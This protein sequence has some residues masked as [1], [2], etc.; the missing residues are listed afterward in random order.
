MNF[1]KLILIF[2]MHGFKTWSFGLLINKKI[3][4]ASVDHLTWHHFVSN[5][6]ISRIGLLFIQNDESINLLGFVDLIFVDQNRRVASGNRRSP[7]EINW[8]LWSSAL[9]CFHL[10][11]VVR[12]SLAF[13][14]WRQ[15][16]VESEQ[17]SF[18]LIAILSLLSLLQVN[19]TS[20]EMTA[21]EIGT[22]AR[23][24]AN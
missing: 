17:Q 1:P 8:H 6:W 19:D 3:R 23:A 9:V 12:P 21:T 11:N 20:P 7:P 13:Y 5:K 16:F 10:P 15:H 18:W 14:Y 22:R 4:V 24:P 2:S